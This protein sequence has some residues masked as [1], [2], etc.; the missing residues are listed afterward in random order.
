M[1]TREVVLRDALCGI[2]L[3]Q[4]V[5]A[6]H[7]PSQFEFGCFDQPFAFAHGFARGLPMRGNV[8][9]RYEEAAELLLIDG[10]EVRDGYLVAAGGADVFGRVAP[11]I[12][13]L[14]AAAEGVA[15]EE[16]NGL[17]RRTR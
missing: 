10:F 6:L 1:P 2:Q 16:V 13:L 9:R 15:S 17:A 14:P 4:F 7:Q 11:H 3:E 12:H 5:L 8:V